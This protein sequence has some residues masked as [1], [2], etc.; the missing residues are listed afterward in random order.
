MKNFFLF[1]AVF[2]VGG[3]LMYLVISLIPKSNTES[4]SVMAE[5][6]D[7]PVH[8]AKYVG[9]AAVNGPDFTTAAD[10]TVDAVVHIRSQFYQKN[11]GYDDYFGA[12]R[13]YLG[14]EPRSNRAYPISGW[15]SG[16]IIENDGYI[17][18]NNHVV[19]GAELIEVI[20]N[21]KRVYEA[22][23]VGL[24]PST[25]LALLKVD[26]GQLPYVGFGNSD[27][28]RVGEW[29]LA[30]GNPFN[31]TSTVT[32]GIVSAKAR[33]INI[34]GIEGAIESFIQTD[35]AVNRGNSGGALVNTSG[36][37][38]GIN[39]AIASNTG[40]YQGYSF[41]IPVNIVKKVIG[42]LKEYGE[43]QR[44]YI[45]VVIKEISQDFA[46]DHGLDDIS[47]VYIDGLVDDGGAMD[48]GIEIG[49]VILSVDEKS[50]NSLAQLLEIVAQHNPGDHL[51]VQI[52]RD[53][54]RQAYD[55]VLRGEDGSAKILSRTDEFYSDRL[56]ATFSQ[57]NAEELSKQNLRGGL[58]ITQLDDDGVLNEGGIKRGFII[59]SVNGIVVDTDAKLN[60]A[61]QKNS[62]KVKISGIYPNG[63]KVTFEFGL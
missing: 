26:A 55:V 19:E 11:E 45:G 38:V 29:V 47:G 59:T 58:K 8:Q 33:N 36:E 41:A 18:T 31:L 48:A 63:M 32:A 2:L 60:S 37:L 52:S 28:L 30:V 24:D 53:G 56:G 21:D 34:L 15:G 16:V 7:I 39:A 43:V 35:A 4:T 42:D 27:K 5:T 13:E 9:S 46:D 40:Y 54:R 20:L 51:S 3:L 62:Y 49:D 1:S 12:L 14:Y 50:V 17:V 10:K 61:L 25:D 22:E 57:L 44:A 23:I 6:E